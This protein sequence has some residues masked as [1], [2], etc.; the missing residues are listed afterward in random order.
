MRIYYLF[1]GVL[2]EMCLLI[3]NFVNVLIIC[4]FL[5]RRNIFYYVINVYDLFY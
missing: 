3:Y 2:F 5:V 1:L 4:V